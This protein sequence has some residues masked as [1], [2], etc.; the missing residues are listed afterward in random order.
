MRKTFLS[1]F[2]RSWT[3]PGL[4]A[5]SLVVSTLVT[6]SWWYSDLLFRSSSDS[7]SVILTHSW[8]CLSRQDPKVPSTLQEN[9]DGSPNLSGYFQLEMFA[10]CILYVVDFDIPGM[11]RHPVV[12]G[13]TRLTKVLGSGSFPLTLLAGPAVDATSPGVRATTC[14]TLTEAAVR[15]QTARQ[16]CL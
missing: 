10:E 15:H 8:T 1:L 7:P 13:P 11:P 2:P 4:S 6:P 3:Y 16:V 5:T 14:S 9:V 12:S